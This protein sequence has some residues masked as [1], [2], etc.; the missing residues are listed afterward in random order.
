MFFNGEIDVLE[1]HVIKTWI[2]IYLN[3]KRNLE[4]QVSLS[5][6]IYK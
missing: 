6:E 1:S 2:V 5:S 3:A 4:L